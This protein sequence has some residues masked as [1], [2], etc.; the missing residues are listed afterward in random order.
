MSDW[1]YQPAADSN[2]PP[3]KRI[4]SERREPGLISFAA[5]H[6]WQ[7]GLRAYLKT[8]HSM[9][10]E[11]IE[12]LPTKPPFVMIANHSSH[13]DA[14]VMSAC[15]PRRLLGSVFP[16]AAGD[17]FFEVP[18]IAVFAASAINALPMWRKKVGRHALDD[19]KN[20]LRAGDAA[21]ILFPEGARTR[22]GEALKWKPGLGMMI[23][24]TDV[25]V[26]PCR[27]FGCFEAMPADR[28]IPK[29]VPIRVR[30]GE[31]MNFKDV[32]DSRA[33]WEEIVEKLKSRVLGME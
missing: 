32:P 12:N 22:D 30:I 15:L 21:Y 11:G 26:V 20:R 19:L 2:L 14:L 4:A 28:K 9:K 33:G 27:L 6:A 31:A 17:V 24:G 13:L 5:H 10:V 29:R 23:A 3:L 1:K 7:T 18:P 16:I 25:P 8:Y